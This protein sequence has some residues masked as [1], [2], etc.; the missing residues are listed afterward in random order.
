MASARDLALQDP[1]D[2]LSLV[3]SDAFMRLQ[4][5]IGLAPKE[6]LGVGRRALFFALLTYVPIA[7]WALAQNRALPGSVE[8]PLL[9]HF[10]IHVRCLV[11]IPL[12]VIAE[13]VSHGI[14]LRLLPQ[15]VH[16]G[17]VAPEDRARFREVLRGV[18]RLRDRTLPWAIVVGVTLSVSWLAP[19]PSANHELVWA[20][21]PPGGFAFVAF[22]FDWVMRPVASVLIF[23]WL[24]RLVL[25]F[26]LNARLARLPVRIVP[27]HPDGAGG[28]GFVDLLPMAFSPVVFAMSAVLASR[29]AH[30]VYYHDLHVAE[31]RP[32]MIAF[33]AF[34]S[35][36][37]L[38]PILPW[39]RPLAAA[40]RTAELDYAALVAR[41]GRLV[42]QRWIEHQEIGDEPILSAPELGPVADT[43]DLYTAARKM[44]PIPIGRRS[45]AAILLPAAIPQ[46]LVV[47]LEVPIKDLL[48]QVASTLL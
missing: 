30:E 21:D 19:P 31:L 24:W 42:H 32:Q 43:L 38:A 11:A 4:R 15:F 7:A 41:H 8:E 27:T 13:Q 36:V 40:K 18:A 44:K 3:R 22:W 37:F 12:L 47:A 34:V 45:L 6:G 23:A 20:G 39:I 48:L 28:L 33:A 9:Q 5:R 17:L 46:L 16:A 14:T 29:W 35:V 2:S 10:G 1:E 25:C 26:V